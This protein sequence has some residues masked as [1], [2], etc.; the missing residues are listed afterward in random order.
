M[1]A[2]VSSE[3]LK[4][5]TTRALWV[6][7]GVVVV[8]S[9]GLPILM[10]FFAAR[11]EVEDLTAASMYDIARAAVQPSGAAVLLL[12][13]LATAGEF[14]H[15][16]VLLSRLAEPNTSRLLLAK[17][18]AV[19]LLGMLIGL[20]VDLLSVL[21]GAVV[22]TQGDLAFQPGSHGVPLVLVVT[23]L[24]IGAFGAFGV[25]IGTLLRSPTLAVGG[26]LVWA[27][28]IEGVLPL[29]LGAPELTD[30]LPSGAFKV[31]VDDQ[32]A[33]AAG[34]LLVYGAALLAAAAV[35]D[36]RRAL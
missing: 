29:V 14:R 5:R 4:L 7:L 33:S 19:G 15:R 17:L 36:R 31:V 24:L 22:L 18:L 13:M 11:P 1:R 34:I 9:A 10:A 3:I 30:R 32:S 23:P 2:L 27:F 16:T 8:L 21:S 25:A 28:V 35:V 26:T 6:V 20:T 12:G